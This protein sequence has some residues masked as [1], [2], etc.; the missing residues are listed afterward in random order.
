MNYQY[1][2]DKVDNVVQKATEH[3]TY[4]YTYDDLY[5]L[6]SATNPPPLNQESY[7]YDAVG[8]RTTDR[9][10]T[11]NWSYNENNQLTAYNNITFEY[12]ANGNT[13]KKIEG[14]TVTTFV[15]DTSDRLIEVKTTDISSNTTTTVA[16]YTYDPFGRRLWKEV[17]NTKT[18]FFYAGEGLL[19]EANNAGL[20]TKL[21]GYQPSSVWGTDP[22]Y[23]KQGADYY[24]FQNDHLGTSQKL[25]TQEGAIAWSA[26]AEA[27]GVTTVAAL[28]I[29]TNNQRFPGQYFDAET[30]LH[31]NWNR[32]YDPN[33]GRYLTSDPIGLDG[34]DNL[35]IYAMANPAVRVDFNGLES[36]SP[37]EEAWCKKHP[38][39][40]G[41][42]LLCRYKAENATAGMQGQSNGEADA[43]RHCI[44]SCCMT[45][46][47][48]I[49]KSKD[50]GDR[51]EDTAPRQPPVE[52]CMD[53]GNN[54]VGRCLATDDPKGDCAS[55]CKKQ[56]KN[57]TSP[58]GPL[59]WP[60]RKPPAPAVCP[61]EDNCS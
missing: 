51:H 13:T 22:I 39:D 55:L 12:D 38:W 31:Y 25:I 7:T 59:Q 44:W 29:I 37:Q 10:I 28:S 60:P 19:A 1:T 36:P 24:F 57:P 14:A 45:Q 2:Y 46:A 32:Y 47:L 41:R 11:G 33:I 50:I 26:K 58:C 43:V 56:S 4:S 61:D 23:L 5:H 20:V 9:N 3:G 16:T 54:R 18:Y 53:K 8:N 15:Y 49:S 34:G 6:K 52:K 48:G 42:A 27:F 40:C 17:S 21:Y 35:Y 30:N